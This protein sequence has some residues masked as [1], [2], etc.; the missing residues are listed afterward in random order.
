MRHPFVA[1]IVCASAAFAATESAPGAQATATLIQQARVVG[2][3]PA[4]ENEYVRVTYELLE[5]AAS[6]DGRDAPRPPVLYLSLFRS[7]LRG[8]R[9]SLHP[10]TPEG[11]AT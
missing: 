8:D 5:Y 3:V 10:I 9:E 11:S 6:R 7:E 4:F 2:Q 1:A